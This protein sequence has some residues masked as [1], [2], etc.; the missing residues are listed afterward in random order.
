MTD[1]TK[2]IAA[3]GQLSFDTL[4]LLAAFGQLVDKNDRNAVVEFVE[5]LLKLNLHTLNESAAFA[6]QKGQQS[7]STKS[8]QTAIVELTDSLKPPTARTAFPG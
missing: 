4:R 6:P 8:R 1:S 3:D 5:R 7:L 2:S